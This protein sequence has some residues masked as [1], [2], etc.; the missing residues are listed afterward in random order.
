MSLPSGYKRLEYIQSSGT[1]YVDSGFKPNNN[2]RVILD[3]EPTSAYSSIV[4]IF[5][6]RDENSGTAANMFVF[7]NNGAN[8]FRTDY[9][10]TQQTMTVSTLLAR[11]TVDKDKNVTTIGSVSASNAASTGQ[12]SN[13]LYLFCTNAAGTE[14]YFAKLKL[15]SCQIYDNGTIIRDYIP[16]QA[17]GGEIGLWDDVN[18][19]FYGNAGTGT[20]TAGP[21][22]PM[23]PKAPIEFSASPLT[24]TTVKLRWTASDG[25]TG[26]KLYKA[27]DLIATL[28][29]TNYTDTVEPFYGY[30]YSVTAYNDDGES[31]ATTLTYYA[32]PENLI[33]YLVTDRTAADVNAG[34]DK[35]TYK[36]SDLNR[37]G[38]V[39]NY[40]AGRLRAA[41]YDPHISPKTDWKDDDWVDPV[42]QAVYL[43]DLAELRKQF[44]MLASTPQVPPRILATAINS[45]DGLT[46][47]WANDIEQILVDINTL[48]TNIAAGWLYSGEIYSGE[49]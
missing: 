11:K 15:Y 23:P 27:G 29:G 3:F 13:N 36:A 31:E 17:A 43:G 38:A 34:N 49:V 24:D 14:N 33:L 28:T 18:G 21:E 25:A 19:V 42:A 16:C 2:S 9:F 8:T 6:T 10:G 44:T 46:Y 39:M 4:G 7:W 47:T 5:G 48:I 26:Y 30:T 20:F 22:V 37:V 1:Q 35:G 32:V 40:V 45:N 41:G 12:C